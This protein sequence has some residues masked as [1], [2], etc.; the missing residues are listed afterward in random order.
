MESGGLVLDDRSTA[1]KVQILAVKVSSLHHIKTKKHGNIKNT[2][3]KNRKHRNKTKLT[4]TQ[5][6]TKVPKSNS[7]KRVRVLI[8]GRDFFYENK[9]LSDW[10]INNI[11]IYKGGFPTCPNLIGQSARFLAPHTGVWN[12]KNKKY[13]KI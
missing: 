12:T 3:K 5:T 1:G 6:R 8:E 9:F 4:K 11:L 13:Y 7:F 2:K 10:Y